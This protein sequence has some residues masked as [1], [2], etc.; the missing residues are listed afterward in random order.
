MAIVSI[1][2]ISSGRQGSITDDLERNYTRTFIIVVDTPITSEIPILVDRRVPKQSDIYT[3]IDG[4]ID[5][6]ALC[7]KVSLKQN[8]AFLWEVTAEYST[9]ALDPARTN[10]NPLL[11]PAEIQWQFQQYN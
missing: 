2:E 7:E 1:N 11:R 5:T 3:S 4:Y 10:R 6:G 9:K 8:A